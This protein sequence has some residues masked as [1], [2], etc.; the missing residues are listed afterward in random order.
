MKTS[1]KTQNPIKF[2]EGTGCNFW[3]EL[4]ATGK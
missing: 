3:A 1:A 4:S 2:P